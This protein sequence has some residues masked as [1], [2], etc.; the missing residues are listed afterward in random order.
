M[1]IF[2]NVYERMCVPIAHEKI[3]GPIAIIEYL[4]LTIDTDKMLIKIRIDKIVELKQN[5]L[6]ALDK[7]KVTLKVLQSLAG[8]LAF[9]TR[10]LTVGRTFCIRI[11]AAMGKVRKSFHFICYKCIEM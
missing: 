6:F 3:E 9:C 11:H 7:K 2:V 1:E 10:A 5:L 4:G 8:S